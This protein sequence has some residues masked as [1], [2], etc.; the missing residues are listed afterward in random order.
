MFADHA[1]PVHFC[2]FFLMAATM[3]LASCA[4]G[5]GSRQASVPTPAP[6]PKPILVRPSALVPLVPPPFETKSVGAGEAR[7]ALLIP[8][9]GRF[10]ELGRSL[11]NAAQIGLF[12]THVDRLTLLPI[13]TKGTPEGAAA[14]ME[15]AIT[16]GAHLVLGPVFS[17]SIQAIKARA[18]TNG[19]PIIGF[20]TDRSVAGQGVYIMGFTPEQQIDDVVGHAISMGKTRFAAFLPQTTAGNRMLDAY[21][22]AI[23]KRRAELVQ[24]EFYAEGDDSPIDSVKRL[25]NYDKRRTA[26]L[27]EVKFLRSFGADDDLAREMRGRLNKTEVLGNLSY[28]AVLMIAGGR[29]IRSIAPLLPYYEIDPKIVQFLGTGVWDDPG[30]HLEPALYGALFAG[31]VPQAAASFSERYNTIYGNTPPRIASLAYDATALAATLLRLDV[32]QPFGPD[33]LTNPRGFSGIDGVFKFGDDGTAQRRLAIIEIRPEGMRVVGGD[34]PPPLA[35]PLSPNPE[36]DIGIDLEF[37]P[38]DRYDF[39]IEEEIDEYDFLEFEDEPLIDALPGDNS[40]P[41]VPPSESST[42]QFPLD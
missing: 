32:Y 20:S 12:D 25:A 33:A 29:M 30:L 17:A 18:Q 38:D 42:P 19:I 37:V 16:S 2:L 8:L 28:D 31:P 27:E 39:G 21:R 13:D 5:F 26:L 3:L 22:A 9:S 6:A 24:V 23:T 41:A 14:A 34:I 35:T 4:G 7:V 1:R 40:M 15:Q 36:D 11:L 10:A